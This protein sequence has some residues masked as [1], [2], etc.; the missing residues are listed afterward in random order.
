MIDLKRFREEQKITQAELCTV[1]G[2]A[3]SY[4]SSIENGKRPLNEKK[5]TLLYKHYGDIVLQYKQSERPI[6]FIEETEAS[7]HPEVQKHIMESLLKKDLKGIPSQFVEALF[8]ER[9]RHDEERKRHDEMNAELIRQ[10][11]SLIRMLEERENGL[12][13]N[14]GDASCADVSESGLGK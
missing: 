11:G 10:N 14:K 5:L 2:I 9:K 13:Q 3:Q 7:L 1:L 6:I 12:V 8:D 4:L